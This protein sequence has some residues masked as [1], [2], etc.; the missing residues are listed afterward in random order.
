VRL[1]W[2]YGP[3]GVGKSTTCWELYTRLGASGLR[4]AYVDIDQLGMCYPERAE[5]ADRHVLKARVLGEVL[6][7]FAEAGAQLVVVSGVLDPHLIP[8]YEEVA[9]EVDLVFCRLRIAREALRRRYLAQGRHEDDVEEMSR[10]AEALETIHPHHSVIDTHGLTPRQVAKLVLDHSGILAA[11][12]PVPETAVGRAGSERSLG[13]VPASTPG[14]LLWLCGPRA[15]GKST[16][17][18]AV[19]QALLREGI[20]SGYLDLQQIGFL[21]E[22][23]VDDPHNHRLKAA[24]VAATWACFQNTGASHLV[25]SDAVDTLNDVRRYQAA[26]PAADWTV[27]RL[28]ATEAEL[29][30]HL[31]LRSQGHGPNLADDQLIGQPASVLG[32]A[33]QNTLA[34]QRQ[35][36]TAGIGHLVVDVSGRTPVAVAH[37]VLAVTDVTSDHF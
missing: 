24:N 26:L 22:A 32:K 10:E 12:S 16:V 31:H 15:V 3:P 30:Q 37:E 14:R 1:L 9:G 2:V 34:N 18:W 35:L 33:L 19:F 17:G 5:D 20:A 23:P 4:Y 28:R 6:T 21:R 13:A 7:E 29:S 36:D 8:L 27:C 11:T 25:I